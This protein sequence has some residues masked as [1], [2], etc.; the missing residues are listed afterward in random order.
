LTGTLLA[1]AFGLQAVVSSLLFVVLLQLFRQM[2]LIRQTLAS[3]AVVD[4][5]RPGPLHAFSRL[6]SRAG[7]A[8]LLL[9]GS[10]FVVL[11]SSAMAGEAFMIAWLPYVV[12][13]PLIAVAAFVLPLYGM[14]GRLVAEK[15]R[16]QSEVEQ[17][18][19]A[20]FGEINRDVDARDMTRLDG[21]NRATGAILQ[22]REILAKL[23]TWPWSAG[24]V[25]AVGTAILLPLGV[26]LLQRFLL[27]QLLLTS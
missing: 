27:S 21:L 26:F 20:L 14:H 24:S 18:L 7:I 4:V 17:R 19:L 3:A 1:A 13:P 15:E 12:I 8:L 22:Q 6:T 10:T 5:F 16:L 2:R 25:R 23:P 9:T 11:P